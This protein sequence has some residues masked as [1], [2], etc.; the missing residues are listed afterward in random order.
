[1]DLLATER[2]ADRPGAGLDPQRPTPRVGRAGAN[3]RARLT[4]YLLSLPS[5]VVLGALLGYP[6]YQMVHIS[7]EKFERAQL[8]GTRPPQWLGLGNYTRVLSDP[9][10]WAVVRNTVVFTV[11]T[12]VLSV[13]G[14]LLVA[15]LMR[16]V[17]RPVKL[18]MIV[19]MMLVWA[20]PP[21]VA[22][23]VFKWMIDA[24]FGVVNYLIDRVPGVNFFK[25]SWFLHPTQGWTVITALVL[26]GAIPFLAITLHAGLTQVPRELTEAATV[27]GANPWQVFRSVTLPI[28]RPLIVIVTTLSVIWDF[29]VFT[30]IWVLRDSKPEREYYSLSIYGFVEAFGGGSYG[31]GSAIALLTVLLMLGAMAFYLRQM[32]K[33]GDAD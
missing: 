11:V 9:F 8:F 1:M 3:W 26:W 22:A 5:L 14:G 30:Q 7:L 12:V 2:P 17:S 16:Q 33:I 21:L 6:L 19:A 31:L 28:L 32:F 20:M 29:Q 18:A 4:P 27:D 13:L 10:F 25:H 15:L 24:D 23:Q